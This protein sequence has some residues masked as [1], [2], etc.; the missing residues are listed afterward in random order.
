MVLTRFKRWPCFLFTV[1]RL[2]EKDAETKVEYAKLHERYT[3]VRL[4]AD[5]FFY[6]YSIGAIY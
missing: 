6:A 3:D 5:Q 1:S 4:L 2:E